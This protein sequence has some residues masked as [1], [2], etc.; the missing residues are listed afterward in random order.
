ML[1][2]YLEA[3][4]P[5]TAWIIGQIVKVVPFLSGATVEFPHAGP[6]LAAIRAHHKFGDSKFALTISLAAGVPR[7]DFSL[8]VDWLE[9]GSPEIGVPMLRVAFP[10]AL[11]NAVASFECANGHVTRSTN[12]AEIPS[13]TSKLMGQYFSNNAAVDPVPAEVPAQK[14]MDLT[15]QH[16][17]SDGTGRRG[18]AQRQQVRPQRQRQHGAADACCAAATIRTRCRNWAITPSASRCGR[19][20]ASGARRTPRAPAMPSTCRS[21]S[22]ARGMQKGKLPA[23]KGCAEILTPNVML[24]GMKKAEDG[25][26][27]IVRL[28]EM[29]G[30]ATTAR[31]KLDAC[32]AAPDAA[33]VET[34]VLERPL[35]NNSAKM[36]KGTLSVK[37]PPFGMVTVKVK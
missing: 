23:R 12:P 28:Y 20:W 9:R 29:E 36:A 30:R 13:F 6:H 25:G 14:W 18:A 21:T 11:K 26:A 32:L 24:S 10:L 5:M 17:G 34:D 16:E 19:T 1:E 22:S 31:V 4:H 7:V 15:G 33:A 3:P 8:E 27:L 37:V 2:Y 35:K